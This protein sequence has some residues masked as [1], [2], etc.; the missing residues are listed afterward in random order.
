[1]TR[2]EKF[3]H[4]AIELAKKGIEKNDGGPF[5][6]IIVEGDAIVGRGNNKVT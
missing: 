5:G 3:M 4:A 2:E 1:M 6:C